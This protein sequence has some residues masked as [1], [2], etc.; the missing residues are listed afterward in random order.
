MASRILVITNKL[1]CH[2]DRVITLLS[3]RGADV[4]RLNTE[5][6]LCEH[7]LTWKPGEGARLATELRAASLNDL[8]AVWYRK[9]SDYALPKHL[10]EFEGFLREELRAVVGGIYRTTTEPV[11]VN[12]LDSQRR[13][14]Y[15]LVQLEAAARVGL[16]IPDTVVT[17]EPAIAA[18]FADRHMEGGIA[19]KSLGS[20]LVHLPAGKT[21][22]TN[23]VHAAV[24]KD[25][26]RIACF[27]HVYQA[28]VPKDA[29]FRITVVG[30]RL[31]ACK[32]DT[33]R[34][35][36]PGT[37]VDWRRYDLENVPHV[38]EHLPS[39]VEAKILQLM[40]NLDLMFGAIDMIRTPDGGYVFLEINPAGQWL[41]VEER[42]DLPISE[43]I[44]DLLIG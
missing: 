12:P 34:S 32:M 39:D 3:H 17:N 16:T 18:E 26:Q 40:G 15:K 19:L 1:D 24:L 2:A 43:A 22:Y 21:I 9:P 4:Y 6:L 7:S 10:M 44:V 11:W 35:P 14:S 31:F 38:A 37:R 8:T 30:K 33:Q 29:E 36:N 41:W 13:A 5:D 28:F 20:G 23:H 27:P 42:T 25:A